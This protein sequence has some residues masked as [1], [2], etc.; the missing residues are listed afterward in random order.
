MHKAS[1][2]CENADFWLYLCQIV[3]ILFG[4]LVAKYTKIDRPAVFIAGRLLREFGKRKENYIDIFV[5]NLQTKHNPPK[6]RNII[7]IL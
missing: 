5:R 1:S 3:T 2:K 6:L 7:I 4:F